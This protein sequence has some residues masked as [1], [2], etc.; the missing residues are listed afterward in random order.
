MAPKVMN[1]QVIETTG[2]A[3]WE[4]FLKTS[5]S[6]AK[7][8]AASMAKNAGHS[9]MT[10][11]QMEI[12]KMAV[13]KFLIDRDVTLDEFWGRTT[14][15]LESGIMFSAIVGP[16]SVVNQNMQNTSRR[17]QQGQ[18]IIGT[19]FKD[20]KAFE[21]LGKDKQGEYIAQDPSGNPIRVTR[22]EAENAIMVPT[23]V[24]E[25][26]LVQAKERKKANESQLLYPDAPKDAVTSNISDYAKQMS[27]NGEN[28]A[29]VTYTDPNTGEKLF[30]TKKEKVNPNTTINVGENGQQSTQQTPQGTKYTLTGKDGQSREIVVGDKE[31]DAFLQNTKII[32]VA[33][34]IQKGIETYFPTNT[35]TNAPTNNQN[36]QQGN[37][38]LS[39]DI[40]QIRQE[41]QNVEAQSTEILKNRMHNSGNIVT[42]TT[43]D[44]K[45]YY[46]KNGDL[47]DNDGTLVVWEETE[48]DPTTGLPG[49]RKEVIS[50]D[51]VEDFV[52]TTFDEALAAVM[53]GFDA[54]VQRNL[55]P[56]PGDQITINQQPYIVVQAGNI[57]QVQDAKGNIIEV[58][59]EAVLA[60]NQSGTIPEVQP[61][62]E[63]QAQEQKPKVRSVENIGGK[64]YEME[65]NEDGS[66][67]VVPKSGLAPDK[68]QDIFNKQYEDLKKSL[69]GNYKWD[70]EAETETVESKF[71]NPKTTIKGIRIKPKQQPAA[72]ETKSKGK[73]TYQGEEIDREMA[74]AMIETAGSLKKKDKLAD[75][76]IEGDEEL[77]GLKEK[78]FPSAKPSYQINGKAANDKQ[79]KLAID[80]AESIDELDKIK[81]AND[82]QFDE[83][84]KAKRE[85][86]AQKAKLR[87]PG[88][89]VE[90]K[91]PKEKLQDEIAQLEKDLKTVR[92]E[93]EKKLRDQIAA[94]KTELENIDNTPETTITPEQKTAI[95]NS[96]LDEARAY[97]EIPNNH[98]NKRSDASKSLR[99]KAAKIGYSIGTDKDG[100]I[101]IFDE[102]NKPVARKIAVKT[103]QEEIDSHKSLEE[104]EN[105]DFIT[106]VEFMIEDINRFNQV[107]FSEFQRGS[108]KSNLKSA[109]TNISIGKKTVASNT[110]LD[111]LESIFS[112]GDI[113]FQDGFSAPVKE[114]LQM[115]ETEEQLLWQSIID[116]DITIEE[117]NNI[118]SD[119]E[120]EQSNTAAGGQD[121]QPDIEQN[122]KEPDNG[123]AGD[124]TEDS[125]EIEAEGDKNTPTMQNLADIQDKVLAG[126][127]LTPE[128]KVIWEKEQ[129]APQG[130][131]YDEQGNLVKTGERWKEEEL[132]TEKPTLPENASFKFDELAPQQKA[133]VLLEDYDNGTNKI[134]KIETINDLINEVWQIEGIS[135]ELSQAIDEYQEARKEDFEVYAGRNDMEMY[136]DNFMAAL[137]NFIGSTEA[138]DVLP[139]TDVP[140]KPTVQPQNEPDITNTERAIL[141]LNS[142]NEGKKGKE[143]FDF[144][145]IKFKFETKLGPIYVF[146]A[147]NKNNQIYFNALTESGETP[148]G[149]SADWRIGA[150]VKQ[151]ID[152]LKEEPA[153][154][155]EEI[156]KA[157]IEVDRNPSE[158]QKKAGNYQK[159]H[160]TIQSMPVSI[161]SVRGDIRKGTDE[162]GKDWSI[163]LNNSYGYFVGSVGYDGDAIDV[164]LGEDPDNSDIFVI[165]QNTK[166]GEFDESKV[167]LGFNSEKEAKEAYLS[168]YEKGWTGFRQIT[169]VNIDDFKKWLY[170]GQKQ[171]K[172]Y[173][174][175]KKTP[176]PSKNPQKNEIDF[177]IE[178]NNIRK[179]VVEFKSELETLNKEKEK[180][181]LEVNKRNGL[182]GDNNA[183]Q[184]DLFGGEGFD[185]NAAKSRIDE[186]N[187]RIELIKT[188]IPELEKKLKDI[189]AT[190]EKE[191]AGKQ[192]I[193]LPKQE[194]P[195]Q[196][197]TAKL[198]HNITLDEFIVLNI[199]KTYKSAYRKP[200][201]EK[202]GITPERIKAAQESLYKKQL[203]MKNTGIEDAGRDLVNKILS[204]YSAKLNNR[205]VP[206][207]DYSGYGDFQKFFWSED[208]PTKEIAEI[209]DP[210]FEPYDEWRNTLIKARHYALGL[211]GTKEIQRWKDEDIV[212]W[213]DR[214]AI[215]KAID[216]K[217]P[218]KGNKL[219]GKNTAGNPLWEDANGNRYIIDGP[220]KIQAPVTV[221]PGQGPVIDSPESLFKKGSERFL[222]PEEIEKF[223]PVE[224]HKVKEY[225]RLKEK[226]PDAI[227]LVRV[228]DYYETFFDD[229][230]VI[231]MILP[232]SAVKDNGILSSG[233]P[234]YQI[235]V[236][237]SKLVKAGRK[238][239]IA[240][241]LRNPNA[242]IKKIDAKPEYSNGTPVTEPKFI[243]ELNMFEHKIK[244]DLPNGSHTVVFY[245]ADANAQFPKEF[246][247]EAALDKYKLDRIEVENQ[248]VQK[249]IGEKPKD[250]IKDIDE[251]INNNP[252]ETPSGNKNFNKDDAK[253]A[254]ERLKNK[255]GNNSNQVNE[256]PANYGGNPVR[257]T[258]QEMMDGVTVAGFFI[259]SGN[260][261]FTKF[262]N[263]MI[264]AIGPG[265][266]PY[267]KS[268]YE[269][270]R[271][272]PGM[273]E[274]AEQMD[275][276]D[277]VKAYDLN[278]APELKPVENS[279]IPTKQDAELSYTTVIERTRNTKT[280]ETIFKVNIIERV[281]KDMFE[282]IREIAKTNNGYYSTFPSNRGFLF[283]TEKDAANFRQDVEDKYAGKKETTPEI[284]PEITPERVVSKEY[285]V[286]SQILDID[287]IKPGFYKKI[288]NT[289]DPIMP[290]A[291]E[292][293]YLPKAFNTRGEE[294]YMLITEQNY[295]QEGDLMTDPRIDWAVYP[296]SGIIEPISFEMNGMGIYKEYISD[297]QVIDSKGMKDTLKFVR[298]IWFPNLLSQGRSML[299]KVETP[300]P[301]ETPKLV[302]DKILDIEEEK[303]RERRNLLTNRN[304][305]LSTPKQL[306]ANAI[307][308]RLAQGTKIA[309]TPQLTALANAA[310]MKLGEHYKDVKELYDIASNALNQYIIEKGDE[311]NPH[312]AT[313]KDALQIV[314][315]LDNLQDLLPTETQR[316]AT[317]VELQ[318]FST[319]LPLAFVANWAAKII[320]EDNMLEPSAGEGNIA[321]FAKTT[322]A[323]VFVNEIDKNRAALLKN[324][325]FDKITNEDAKFIGMV[326]SLSGT[327]ISVVVMN[328]PFSRDIALGDKLDLHAAEKHID[329]ALMKLADGGRLVAIVGRG[330]SFESP[331]HAPWW[332]NVKKQ[333][334]VL[335]NI[336]ISGSGY[337]KKG[338]TFDNRLLIIDK[339]GET[340]P[341]EPIITTEVNNYR[342]LISVLQLLPDRERINI[343]KLNPNENTSTGN[344]GQNGPILFGPGPNVKQ[345]NVGGNGRDGGITNVRPPENGGSNNGLRGDGS[346]GN[347]GISGHDKNGTGSKIEQ[348]NDK[349]SDKE[350]ATNG[351]ATR[352]DDA[353][354]GRLPDKSE[355][356]PGRTKSGDSIRLVYTPKI[357]GNKSENVSGNYENYVPEY[358]A[359]NSKPHP[360]K[361]VESVAMASVPLPKIDYSPQLNAKVVE[362]GILSS[363]QIEDIMLAGNAHQQVLPSGLRRGFFL[364]AGTGYGKGRTLAGIILDNWNQGYKK[365]IWLSANDK[366]HY[367]SADY[368]TAV[369]GKK[370]A[371]IKLVAPGKK[372][373]QKEGILL[374][375][376]GVLKG[377][378]NPNP[379]NEE[380]EYPDSWWNDKPQSRIQQIAQWLG[381]DFDGLI[382]F[383]E[384]HKMG[385]AIQISERGKRG[386]TKPAKQALA[387]VEL[388]KLL[389]NAKIVYSSATGATEVKNLTYAPRL[390]LW[391]DGTA[392]GSVHAFIEAINSSGV[393]GMEII[394]KD[395]KAMGLYTA[396]TLSFDGVEY[397][398]V[399]HNLTPPQIKLYNQIS[400]AF[401]IILK[402]V[403][404]AIDI[405]QS[406]SDAK[407][408]AMQ[409]LWSSQQ[410]FFSQIITTMMMPSLLTDIQ[411][412]LSE[413]KA[414][415]IQLTNTNEAQQTRSLAEAKSRL[416]EGEEVNYD[417]LDMS[418]KQ[419]LTNLVLSHFPV[420]QFQEVVDPRTGN[421][422]MVPVK[423]ADGNFVLNP[424]AIQMR[425]RL[426][427]KLERE[428]TLP[429]GPL[430]MILNTFGAENVAEVTGRTMRIVTRQNDSGDWVK[431]EEKR[432]SSSPKKELNDFMEGDRMILVF[433]D[434][435]AAGMSAHS[436]I[437]R[438]NQ[439][440]RVHYVLQPGWKADTTVQGLGRSHRA[441]QANAPIVK[442]VTT[443]LKAQYRFLSSIARRLDQLGALSKGSRQTGSQG[444]I[445]GSY[446]LE[447]TYAKQALFQFYKDVESRAIDGVDMETLE[448]QMALKIYKDENGV[449]TYNDDVV[450]NTTQ[451]L[452]RIM[453][454]R[455]DIMDAV[456][457]G[458]MDNL[459]EIVDNAI[460]TGNYDAGIEMVTANS[461]KIVDNK[462][463]YT[464]SRT[465]GETYLTTI[466]LQVPVEK[467]TWDN[468][469]IMAERYEAVGKFQGYFQEEKSGRIYAMVKQDIVTADGERET[470]F[471][472][473]SVM[474]ESHIDYRDFYGKYNRI[475]DIKLAEEL[476]NKDFEK[477]PATRTKTDHI[478]KGLILPIW[479]RLPQLIRVKRYVDDD[480]IPH[481]GRWF[482]PREAESILRTFNIASNA[483]YNTS[484]L[485]QVIYT[486]GKIKLANGFELRR[487][488]T[489]GNDVVVVKNANWVRDNDRLTRAG[490]A[491]V[492]KSTMSMA[493]E[494][495]IPFEKAEQSINK[496]I[497]LYNSPAIQVLDEYE[498]P[499][500]PNTN[501]RFG[502]SEPGVDYSPAEYPN[503]IKRNFKIS[504]YPK[505][506][507]QAIVSTNIQKMKSHPEY[508]A[509][510][511]QGD[512]RAA[513][514]LA[515]DLL[516]P[517][518][519]E[520]IK[521]MIN[522]ERK[523]YLLPIHQTDIGDFNA[524]PTGYSELL[525]H[526][527]N[528]PIEDG[529]SRINKESN[530]NA[531]LSHRMNNVIEF[532]G[533]LTEPN[534]DFIIVDDTYT[535][536]NTVVSMIEYVKSLGGNP[537][538]VTTLAMSRYGK[539][540]IP[541]QQRLNIV[542]KGNFVKNIENEFNRTKDFFTGAELHALFLRQFQYP[543][544]NNTGPYS[545]QGSSE[546]I[547]GE[548]E[549]S[550][551]M[552]E[553]NRQEMML[554]FDQIKLKYPDKY[555]L[556]KVGDFYETFGNDAIKISNTLGTVLM[557]TPDGA[558]LTGF[559]EH[560]LETY[561]PKLARAGLSVA[562]VHELNKIDTESSEKLKAKWETERK[563]LQKS[564]ASQI[565]INWENTEV[566]A[567]RNVTFESD[568]KT[569]KTQ[570]KRNYKAK[571]D[572]GVTFAERQLSNLG[573]LTFMGDK[574]T[575]PSKIT[576]AN[577]I[578]FIF[579]NLESASSE[580][581]FAAM[582]D[583]NGEYRVLYLGTGSSTGSVVD[584][585]QIISAA[586]EFGSAKVCMVHNHP[587]GT[588]LPSDA[589]I[590][591]SR[592]IERACVASGIEFMSSVIIDTDRG[593]YAVISNRNSSTEVFD[594]IAI[595]D[596]IYDLDVHHFDRLKMHVNSTQKTLIQ[597]SGDVAVFMSKQKRGTV[598]KIHVI[599]LDNANK[600]NRYYF[601]DETISTDDLIKKLLADVGKYGNSVILASNGAITSNKISKIKSELENIQSR[602]LDVLTIKQDKG[603]YEYNR[604]NY[605]SAGDEGLLEP[606]TYY[607]PNNL[608][609]FVSDYIPFKSKD[610][611]DNPSENQ[612]FSSKG[613]VWKYPEGNT[614]R[615]RV[616]SKVKSLID[617]HM[618]KD[619]DPEVF[620][621]RFRKMKRNGTGGNESLMSIDIY[622]KMPS[623]PGPGNGPKTFYSNNY[624]PMSKQDNRGKDSEGKSIGRNEEEFS[625]FSNWFN[626]SKAVDSQGRPLRLY[627]A[628]VNDFGTFSMKMSDL[629]AHVGTKEQAHS[630]ITHRWGY[631]GDDPYKKN[632]SVMPVYISIKNPIRVKD[633]MSFNFPDIA[634]SLVLNGIMSQEI[635]D[636]AL[637]NFYLKKISIADANETLRIFLQGKGI[638]GFVYLN[639]QE[640]IDY[641][642][643]FKDKYLSDDE[644]K[645]KYPDAKDSWVVFSPEQIKSATDNNGLFDSA[646]P[647]VVEEIIGQYGARRLDDINKTSTRMNNLEM[648]IDME[649]KGKTPEQIWIATNWQ[650][651]AEGM[652]RYEIMDN[653]T[654]DEEM[655]NNIPLDTEYPITDI[656]KAP[657]FYD[658]YPEMKN[659]SVVKF[660]P[661][662][663]IMR[664]QQG[665]F[666]PE[667]NMLF[668][669]S[670]ADNKL[671]TVIHELQHFIQQQ[672]GFPTGANF[673]TALEFS[674]FDD[675]KKIGN[676]IIKD[677]NERNADYKSEIKYYEFVKE[678]L[679]KEDNE[680]FD[681]MSTKN[682]QLEYE[683]TKMYRQFVD[684]HIATKE[685]RDYNPYSDEPEL[686]KLQ[687]EINIEIKEPVKDRLKSILQKHVDTWGDIQ[688]GEKSFNVF[689]AAYE[690]IEKGSKGLDYKIADLKIMIDE[691]NSISNNILNAGSK[692][693]L[694]KLID[695]NGSSYF[696]EIY[697]RVA[698]EVEARNAQ[699]RM[700]LSESQRRQFPLSETEDILRDEF[701]FP[702][703]NN[704]SAQLSIAANRP[705][706]I[707][708]DIETLETATKIYK[709]K[710]RV[711]PKFSDIIE[712]M[713]EFYI[714][715]TLPIRRHF[716][717]I[718]KRGGIIDDNSKPYRDMR[719]SFGRMEAMY[720]EYQ[721]Q[722][723]NP[724]IEDLA[725]FQ[726]AG[727]NVD[728]IGPYMIAKHG[729]ERNRVMRAEELAEWILSQPF[730]VN[731]QFKTWLKDNTIKS[732]EQMMDEFITTFYDGTELQDIQIKAAELSNK[733]YSGLR[734]LDPMEKY[735][736]FDEL[737]ESIIRGFENTSPEDLVTEFWNDIKSAT[738]HTLDTWYK[739][740]QISKKEYEKY[741][742]QFE[743]FVPLRGWREG[744][745]KT[746]H[747]KNNQFGIGKS[748]KHK[749]GRLSLAD[750]PLAY[751]QSVAFKAI[752]E[753]VSNEI[754][755]ALWE[756][757]TNNYGGNFDGMHFL[758]R[759]YLV[760]VTE[761]NPETEQD[762][763]FWTLY[764]DD[765]GNLAKPPKELFEEG[766]AKAEFYNENEKLRTKFN[767]K[768]SEVVV[769]K[770]GKVYIVAFPDDKLSIAQAYNNQ[771]TMATFFGHVFDARKLGESWLFD[772]LSSWTNFMKRMMTSYNPVF[773]FTNFFRDQPEAAITQFIRNDTALA[774]FVTEFTPLAAATI[775]R[776]ISGHYNPNDPLQI[777][778]KKFYEAGGTTGFTHEKT[779]E[780]LE[781]E[782]Y[783]A[784]QKRINQDSYSGKIV[785][786]VANVLKGIEHWN[787]IFEDTT[788]FGVYLSARNKGMTVRDA[789]FESRISSVD[790]NMRGKGTKLIEAGFAFFK[791]ASNAL[792]KNLQL[793]KVNKKKFISALAA[794]A[795]LGF[796]EALLN[797]WADKDN[798]EYYRLNDYV[799]QNYVTFP[800]PFSNESKYVRI[801]LPQF[802][803]GFHAMGVSA[804]DYFQGH[805]TLGQSLGQSFSNLVAGISPIDVTAFIQDGKL[806]MAPLIP[807]TIRPISEA[808]FTNKD[809][810]GSKIAIEPFTKSLEN[811]LADSGLHKKNV[812]PAIEF[813]TDMIFKAAGG[814]DNLKFK[815]ENGELKYVP[816]VADINPSK[817][818]H[819]IKGYFGG[820]GRVL[821][822]FVTSIIQFANPNDSLDLDNVP[823][824]NA[825]IRNVPEEK[826]QIIREYND[827]KK[828]IG[829]ADFYRSK[830]NSSYNIE[831]LK[832][833][834]RSDYPKLKARFDATDS[835]IS[836]IMEAKG[837]E[838]EEAAQT[839]SD[840]M[841]DF[842]HDVKQIKQQQ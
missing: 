157:E 10:M 561:L 107:K 508:N 309:N 618:V 579:K 143:K 643:D 125:A 727:V 129:L 546:N 787:R 52:S 311:F 661:W 117:L 658:A 422:L 313:F 706:T 8:F 691:K 319:P 200:Y 785:N 69:A 698:G 730:S 208:R 103:T 556:M 349:G 394:A 149:F 132:Q 570:K 48:T 264:D 83:A 607:K 673:E 148:T 604:F 621:H 676:K 228:G 513:F 392:F 588:L 239:A 112:S 838:S 263:A 102:Q 27:F 116:K 630:I 636:K 522:P 707:A 245:T 439:A 529:I 724:V 645:E 583:A 665:G 792:Q 356:K 689:D 516:K 520:Q 213:S 426:I 514:V 196:T 290:F 271:Q 465:G 18:V 177:L 231:S 640:G 617:K 415:V 20:G 485:V 32:D 130:Y 503:P 217:L 438:K 619:F 104:Y 71:D 492:V 827:I 429:E 437:V 316:S 168:N 25:N 496:I 253:A 276:Q 786:T 242:P 700:L 789:A 31:H 128:E 400:D 599:I 42:V 718:V 279:P 241:E 822:D 821:T 314:V 681:K 388:Q 202:A 335:A 216:S 820:T 362:E 145:Q 644:Y 137:N 28:E 742:N 175:Y 712:G 329:G 582:I 523:T 631:T 171:R 622:E 802:Y 558:T 357:V 67:S 179:Q 592:Q 462:L 169:K 111:E 616:F 344:S 386:S 79:V 841:K 545:S 330:M 484:Q 436:S 509:A 220:V 300:E 738:T 144:D 625:N 336:S 562:V 539:E 120:E 49:M 225:R 735:E 121:G 635:A 725:D 161:E 367:D 267:L 649:K 572:N 389:P 804:Y 825:F 378:F 783:K 184:G 770:D 14:E 528:L 823:F 106:F 416:K 448:E 24:F 105:K 141:L 737:A 153:T 542:D 591:I 471:K 813:F 828:L 59:K 493:G 365:A 639:R 715:E 270:I 135:E 412:N 713:R 64:D 282:D 274:Y 679:S 164:F 803:R 414:I 44:G 537:T 692:N 269:S 364:G 682:R 85:K 734:P 385:N 469:Q 791:A 142:L 500:M 773:P 163:E 690:L 451:F 185:P 254:I 817:I 669:T 765:E 261:K 131:K 194:I 126:E 767:A 482:N 705:N 688:I 797:D 317:M 359:P 754:K 532:E 423:D 323:S 800:L 597:S 90:T 603:I 306:L 531:K 781:K 97:D 57:Y 565:Q 834:Y 810:M 609:G 684:N 293:Q 180:L 677:I 440:R 521:G 280:Q 458:F 512:G 831:N 654:F 198:H 441:A 21:I 564:E 375:T 553:E 170:D 315:E 494:F 191:N 668:I 119:Y 776:N 581:T 189:I 11:E 524:I 805:K 748:L 584:T 695:E 571:I 199:T 670:W 600:V 628:T 12:G 683:E 769:K 418:P 461:T 798:D 38:K 9:V 138:P 77:T 764:R 413:G 53:R 613:E 348:P 633:E 586:R 133:Q 744:A 287:N 479:H 68:Q 796:L 346:A 62:P 275:S 693:E 174:D 296:K 711:K 519:V 795:L 585:K 395:L 93:Y 393:A 755:L 697:A 203:L 308:R 729:L 108:E 407:R 333:Y 167:M 340:F 578:A 468:V 384:S 533:N 373:T 214:D 642:Y 250:I 193:E 396:K 719:N 320:P 487:V 557:K 109:I 192:E 122:R 139:E 404:S 205:N 563:K 321:T 347:T 273:E 573:K 624:T 650:R 543:Y 78:Y 507:S 527:L 544:K 678:N 372:I 76:T 402:G 474:A 370:E 82:T 790:F 84:I 147:S 637:D 327:P 247:N 569:I 449:R 339:T 338:T 2:K 172:P 98:T 743:N 353:Q 1:P 361:L 443:N 809:F 376:Y 251:N 195:K 460:A 183:V 720:R 774:K 56:Q 842:I 626:G 235:D 620:D 37:P 452:N 696:Y 663:D 379:R 238:V 555:V 815:I 762:E 156:A 446:N 731:N 826:W 615:A 127:E 835:A 660:E 406:D 360:T 341:S 750:N 66:Y 775:V 772:G 178:R 210:N 652:W 694:K 549:V 788:R 435:G 430:D 444:V 614:Q 753:Q 265:I 612:Y 589:D 96:L 283:K 281:D 540:I 292:A 366:S 3:I 491:F 155:K 324:L 243:P 745:A 173:G 655:F 498:N 424:I 547:V 664:Q 307:K 123:N 94:K 808:Y 629:G 710:P 391:G 687:D 456:F 244:Y 187:K 526:K 377:N 211:F 410:R 782:L 160:V 793:Y 450:F 350:P 166:T 779:V 722:I 219:I 480:G 758:K 237:L 297:G 420:I 768:Q 481:L 383:D 611:L 757:V 656:I 574:L 566:P 593:E 428:L 60:E 761:W 229:A 115:W 152:R 305:V 590:R 284:K 595:S 34:F 207:P 632:S 651:G 431:V 778:L 343:K 73:Y 708:D 704:N 197:D 717:E 95:I 550:F 295:I 222:T 218:K 510:K 732:T 667:K 829:D 81:I 326:S 227:L 433:S 818:E 249:I 403:N 447:S 515:N 354:S 497:E 703:T 397:D 548:P 401:Q 763:T 268:L 746:M 506:L 575:G 298:E 176:E 648:A 627:H 113:T 369:G 390:G 499:V 337:S 355:N 100:N 118:F 811:K 504:E 371:I 272:W 15:A 215:I 88:K 89:P 99:N 470:K 165:D 114:F 226:H 248:N 136:E 634:R 608:S 277:Y 702:T 511:L 294:G 662:F 806:S 794:S 476:W 30:V 466:D 733:D 201:Y 286:L 672:E 259:E 606:E 432:N 303:A 54:E 442:L 387:G 47:K 759:A 328:P 830:A 260:T 674:S 736:N 463:I 483:K 262:A 536:G 351:T 181:V 224:P 488:K 246:E 399:V 445:D 91:S 610:W 4:N 13:D 209:I 151:E 258:M 159:G 824:I 236:Y 453:S 352:S 602:L 345:P 374:I 751:L 807:T 86:F 110:L 784:L 221:I 576:S 675:L 505:T 421:K 560:N 501:N 278:P 425:D 723:I 836:L 530:T 752:G 398:K 408:I 368:W 577:D 19:T 232:I 716:D 411:Q 289:G 158:A 150:I 299:P 587:S 291:V 518:V 61:Q 334:H 685:N 749:E 7:K 23:E 92:P 363:A 473:I 728:S 26:S 46:V 162:N 434:A 101:A 771:N 455:V 22:E 464:D 134:A 332:N 33:D 322:G 541:T 812:N 35:T 65:L 601:E 594:K 502:V 741:L 382:V 647:D 75:L 63:Q 51:D 72:P 325:N 680:Y 535:S 486:G 839:V 490:A 495:Q 726:K 58:P 182:F 74:Q 833:Y 80:W 252:P 477:A 598:N 819:L 459:N 605:I 641:K 801:P 699:D 40:E 124:A 256:E 646:K 534:S 567:K 342:E 517:E 777:E 671:S 475:S 358:V 747:F 233:F 686:I 799:R 814:E 756:L 55:E 472:R 554:K 552:V 266:K 780:Q 41:R 405:T 16:F 551:G 739:G 301:V 234:A 816:W 714:D 146:S 45:M 525:S 657:E 454:L 457:D 417:E 154:T 840:L 559:P 760:Q 140:E 653:I 190:A 832:K 36:G 70:I 538:V 766:L 206:D 623:R 701:I 580:N 489:M 204:E 230:A 721:E 304:A 50:T 596:K 709:E 223:K 659:I 212:D 6:A 257:L 186:I 427:E 467:K 478:V 310:G 188:S 240:D 29:I 638:D 318:Q 288:G 302:T 39:S 837:F 381:K 380:N 255:F 331:T 419:I 409:H 285:E 312:Q 666:N 87:E 568:P 43:R 740:Q 5:P 17:R